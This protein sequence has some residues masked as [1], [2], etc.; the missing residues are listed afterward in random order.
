MPL[1]QRA[2]P[3]GSSP[4]RRKCRFTASAGLCSPFETSHLLLWNAFTIRPTIE[5]RSVSRNCRHRFVVPEHVSPRQGPLSSLY[6]AAA[7]GGAFLVILPQIDATTLSW[8]GLIGDFLVLAGLCVAAFY[9]VL[10]RRLISA[11]DGL[12]LAAI[13]QSAALAFAVLAL[14]VTLVLGISPL[15]PPQS[16]SKSA[17][18]SPSPVFCNSRCPSGSI[19][20]RWSICGRRSRRCSCRSSRSVVSSSL[21]FFSVKDSMSGRR[22]VQP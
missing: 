12:H 8:R 14:I 10:S 7:L 17:P 9:V 19:F 13:Q 22:W 2:L 1:F 4:S 20:A 3:S 6:R 21:I 18:S 11:Y 15:D 5:P 16:P